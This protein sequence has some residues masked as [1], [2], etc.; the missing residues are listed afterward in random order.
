MSETEKFG[1]DPSKLHR[2][3]SP[4]TSKEAAYSVDT[5]HLE[6]EVLEIIRSFGDV[7]CISDEV[8]F[9]P[10]MLGKPYSSVTARYKALMDRNLIEDTGERR[11][12]QSG[13]S[14]RVMRAKTSWSVDEA[15]KLALTLQL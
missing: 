12:G 9:H 11:K 8:R 3:E 2:L 14:M 1:T 7:G 10:A 4:D 6:Y 13:R 15:I 5:T